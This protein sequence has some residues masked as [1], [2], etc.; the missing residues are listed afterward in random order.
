LLGW[1]DKIKTLKIM[2]NREIQREKR[3]ALRGTADDTLCN[4][5]TLTK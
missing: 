3:K 1:K 4:N 2:K 5:E